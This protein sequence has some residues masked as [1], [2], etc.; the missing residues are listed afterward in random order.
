MSRFGLMGR[1][2]PNARSI[3]PA[4]HHRGYGATAPCQMLFQMNLALALD[5]PA[6]WYRPAA[7]TLRISAPALGRTMLWRKA[8]Q[9]SADSSFHRDISEG[10]EYRVQP[11]I[12][13]EPEHREH[14][15]LKLRIEF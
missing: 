11:G 9:S 15:A 5:Q 12:V 4:H 2:G 3:R 1:G 7:A 8:S 14:D 13:A 10:P 6:V